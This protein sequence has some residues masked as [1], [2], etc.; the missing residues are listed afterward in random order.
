[1]RIWVLAAGVAVAL[2]AWG[3]ASKLLVKAGPATSTAYANGA[4]DR[5]GWKVLKRTRKAV[6]AYQLRD[7]AFDYWLGC[8]HRDNRAV[9][10]T[11]DA[12]YVKRIVLRGNYVAFVER[13]YFDASDPPGNQVTVIGLSRTATEKHNLRFASPLPRADGTVAQM[14]LRSDGAVAWIGCPFDYPGAELD[15]HPTDC[16]PRKTNPVYYVMKA[17]SRPARGERDRREI[18]VA[19]GADIDPRS[20]RLRRGGF[21]WR[22]GGETHIARLR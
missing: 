1:M 9:Q 18:I 14:V 22:Q 11:N 21:A 17:H 3:V 15:T 6:V 8:L 19:K 10:L 5:P 13:Q 20:L 2:S 4:C 16:A 12:E 7:K